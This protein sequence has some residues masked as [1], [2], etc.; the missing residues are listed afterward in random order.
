MQSASHDDWQ[1]AGAIPA[2]LLR[3]SPD[4]RFAIVVDASQPRLYVFRN[5]DGEPQYVA[6]Y[7]VTI[8]RDGAGKTREGD[9]RTPL[10]VY[11]ITT[12][13]PRAKLTAFYG[14]AAYPLD[15]PNAWDRRLG[16]TGYGIWVDGTPDTVRERPPRASRGCVVLPPDLAAI[17]P[18]LQPGDTRV[19]IADGIHWEKRTAMRARR[20]DRA[21]DRWLAARLG[22]LQCE[23]LLYA[24]CDGLSG[25][26]EHLDRTPQPHDRQPNANQR[27]ADRS[28]PVSLSRQ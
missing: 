3:L 9:D 21:G 7:H 4:Q 25:K 19:I 8:G 24:L 28:E 11:F 13:I 15:Y 5:V 23:T 12:H 2:N 6:D 26:S 16:H 18:Y 10:G 22:K 20:A 27:G 14:P 1:H 17:E